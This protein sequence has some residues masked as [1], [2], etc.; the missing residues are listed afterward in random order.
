[1]GSHNVMR[2][3]KPNGG[4]RFVRSVTHRLGTSALKRRFSMK[5]ARKMAPTAAA[6]RKVLVHV[7]KR[8]R[9][10]LQIC[11]THLWVGA[12]EWVGTH[13]SRMGTA[14][15]HMWVP[16]D[17]QSYPWAPKGAHYRWAPMGTHRY[18]W[19]PAHDLQ[20]PTPWAHPEPTYMH[21]TLCQTRHT[22]SKRRSC[23]W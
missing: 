8:N 6:F 3:V 1:M 14:W 22:G 12:H 21:F 20:N 18:T 4:I 23:G 10:Y 13:G 15:M 9:D 16:V 2:W 5:M 17:T 7:R 19:I 11:I